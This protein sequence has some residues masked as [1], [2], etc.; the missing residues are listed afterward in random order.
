MVRV[1][2]QNNPC[3]TICGNTEAPTPRDQPGLSIWQDAKGF[4]VFYSV[5]G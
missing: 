4:A 3:Y 2:H 5:T 1:I